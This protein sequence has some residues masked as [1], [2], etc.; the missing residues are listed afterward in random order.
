MKLLAALAL[1]STVTAF[2]FGSKKAP[3]K[4][5]TTPGV[6]VETP[7]RFKPAFGDFVG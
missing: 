6:S 4:K 5:A 3:A 1:V 7:E 2:S